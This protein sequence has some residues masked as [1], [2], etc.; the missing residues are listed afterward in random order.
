[1]FSSCGAVRGGCRCVTHVDKADD[2]G[3]ESQRSENEKADN[4]NLLHPLHLKTKHDWDWQQKDDK[5]I[6]FVSVAS[7]T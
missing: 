4:T 6:F 3:N 7:C 1:M 2:G 5:L